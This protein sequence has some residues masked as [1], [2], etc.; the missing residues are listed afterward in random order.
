MFDYSTPVCSDTGRYWTLTFNSGLHTA[1]SL[2]CYKMG[3]IVIER[4]KP[5]P[6]FPVAPVSFATQR[7]SRCFAQS[8][9][10]A[11]FP[12]VACP[13]NT[14][15]MIAAVRP[16]SSDGGNKYPCA[17]VACGEGDSH[18]RHGQTWLG[19]EFY[20]DSALWLALGMCLQAFS[21]AGWCLQVMLK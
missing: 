16:S 2:S 3:G 20:I 15:C 21:G 17:S 11:P 12:A 8:R 19:V 7:D 18:R 9:H 5:T 10:T 1:P 6:P 14:G 13:R 4:S